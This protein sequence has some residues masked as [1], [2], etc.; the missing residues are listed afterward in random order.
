[1][2]SKRLWTAQMLYFQDY[3]L[4]SVFY[5]YTFHIVKYLKYKLRALVQFIFI[6]YGFFCEISRFI[7]NWRE[8]CLSFVRINVTFKVTNIEIRLKICSV[9]L[10]HFGDEI[11]G[12]L[13]RN[14]VWQPC[15]TY[16]SFL[17]GTRVLSHRIHFVP[18]NAR[19]PRCQPLKQLILLIAYVICQ[20]SVW[21]TYS[22][23]GANI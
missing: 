3:V 10:H 21:R 13:N 15:H 12:L 14:T 2:Y 23:N 9:G 18:T 16:N 1:M 17:S 4:S 19:Y 8:F 22:R 5:F 6:P 20:H 11:C 7:E